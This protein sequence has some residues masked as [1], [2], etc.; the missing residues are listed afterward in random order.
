M[1]ID[2]KQRDCPVTP[3]CARV[4]DHS[5]LTCGEC[6]AVD[7]TGRCET[8]VTMRS[9]TVVQTAHAWAAPLEGEQ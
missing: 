3:T 5:H 2:V 7:F 9:I 6:G 1:R 4:G 8:C